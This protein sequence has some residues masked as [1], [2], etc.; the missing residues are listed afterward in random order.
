MA[1]GAGALAVLL[2]V[3][4]YLGVEKPW[5]TAGEKKATGGSGG[6]AVSTTAEV[7]KAQTAPAVTPVEAGASSAAPPTAAA[8][9]TP[10][11]ADSSAK[12]GTGLITDPF[13]LGGKQ[14]VVGGGLGSAAVCTVESEPQ[15]RAAVDGGTCTFLLL[16]G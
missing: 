15:L 10:T 2:G 11:K 16:T 5:S 8:S 6:G 1:F 13:G 9:T 12:P 14:A 7:I 3:A 4:V